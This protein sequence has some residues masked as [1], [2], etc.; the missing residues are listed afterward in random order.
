MDPT[1]ETFLPIAV[2]EMKIR[3]ADAA[4]F[5]VHEDLIVSRRGI[6]QLPQLELLAGLDEYGGS[7]DGRLAR[8]GHRV[9]AL[10]TAIHVDEARARVSSS[11]SPC[12]R[13]RRTKPVRS[14]VESHLELLDR[15][16]S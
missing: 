14:S 2:R 11:P 13:N 15:V 8:V 5:D 16:V 12:S 7:H 6:W 1:I 3:V 9:Q 4:R 10:E